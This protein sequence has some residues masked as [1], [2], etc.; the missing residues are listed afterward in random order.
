LRGDREPAGWGFL[1]AIC[2]FLQMAKPETTRREFKYILLRQQLSDF[3]EN[4]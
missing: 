1:E 2:W 4:V 3:L